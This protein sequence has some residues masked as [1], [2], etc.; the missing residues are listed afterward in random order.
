M[1]I[2]PCNE[3]HIKLLCAVSI[4]GKIKSLDFST[5][6][7]D[8]CCNKTQLGT[9][10][11]ETLRYSYETFWQWRATV[12][13]SFCSQPADE[14]K[15]YISRKIA[16]RKLHN[17][18]FIGKASIRSNTRLTAQMLAIYPQDF[19]FSQ[20]YIFVETLIREIEFVYPEEWIVRR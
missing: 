10:A 6:S 14:L 4:K 1:C 3:C 11:A 15:K 17:K 8:L 7:I 5:L 19:H 13:T 20:C 16:W 18:R 12:R 2:Y 9:G